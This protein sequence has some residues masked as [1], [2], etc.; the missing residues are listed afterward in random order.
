MKTTSTALGA[1]L[2]LMALA[3]GSVAVLHVTLGLQA[4]AMIGA[5]NVAHSLP[6]GGLDSQN[7]FYG[8]AFALYAVVFWLAARDLERYVLLLVWALGLLLLGGAARLISV[9]LYGWPAAPIIA[10][11]VS[12]VVLSPLLAWWAWRDLQPG[13]Q[14]VS[15]ET[16]KQADAVH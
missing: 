2:K 11:G 15:G 13:V 1:V 10:L 3:C 12:E 9:A 4:D 16:A 14:T 5:G 6:D 8:A 7:R